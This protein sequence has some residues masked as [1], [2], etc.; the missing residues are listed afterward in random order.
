MSRSAWTSISQIYVRGL[1]NEDVDGHVRRLLVLHELLDL[2]HH[3]RAIGWRQQQRWRHLGAEV[4][5]AGRGDGHR[6]DDV[7]RGDGGLVASGHRE[8]AVQRTP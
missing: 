4:V 1:F 2:R 7:Q 8:R 3:D 5:R 6:R